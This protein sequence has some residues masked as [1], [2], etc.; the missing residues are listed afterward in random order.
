MRA[1][2]S[3][4]LDNIFDI[5]ICYKLIPHFFFFFTTVRFFFDRWVLKFKFLSEHVDSRRLS[6]QTSDSNRKWRPTRY[7]HELWS[8]EEFPSPGTVN[9][10]LIFAK[11]SPFQVVTSIFHTRYYVYIAHVGKK[12]NLQDQNLK[13]MY[14]QSFFDEDDL[15]TIY[16]ACFDREIGD[17][18]PFDNPRRNK[19]W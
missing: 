9:F 7:R 10:R 14:Q 13:L 16:H 11:S 3:M 17:I 19:W 8:Q 5:L 6:V 18:C 2:V 4:Y 15:S 1:S 12:L